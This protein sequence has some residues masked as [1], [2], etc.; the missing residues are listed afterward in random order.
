MSQPIRA[1]SVNQVKMATVL[2]AIVT[3]ILE[4]N[5]PTVGAG[6]V[7]QFVAKPITDLLNPPL[8]I[9]YLP[10]KFLRSKDHL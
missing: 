9:F 8:Q 1:R 3:T 7:V 2:E 5:R 6:F 10:Q 4:K